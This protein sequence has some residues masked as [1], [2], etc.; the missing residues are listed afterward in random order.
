[1]QHQESGL[2]S[3][4]APDACAFCRH[5]ELSHI[6]KETPSFLLI[7][8]HAP[9]V[10]GHV[11]IIPRAHYA[12]YGAMPA[13]LDAELLALKQEVRRFV[14]RYYAPPVFWEHGVFRQTVFHAHLHCIP[15]GVVSYDLSGP[16]H[17]AVISS[18]DDIRAWYAREGHYFYMED[19]EKALLFAGEMERYTHVVRDV[20]WHGM[21]VAHGHPG[22]RSAQQRREEAGPLLEAVSEKWRQFQQEEG[23]H[24]ADESGTR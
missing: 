22:W 18:Q 14:T 21:T 16:L 8:D 13:E 15:F 24:Y 4:T 19:S 12:C 10:E 7:A 20:L 1:M 11:L 23:V 6:L 5:D 17:D 3:R 9:L 2:E